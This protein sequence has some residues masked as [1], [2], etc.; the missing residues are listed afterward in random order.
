[1]DAFWRGEAI[2]VLLPSYWVE[3]VIPGG[4][5]EVC[6]WICRYES[7]CSRQELEFMRLLA[8]QVSI[9]CVQANLEEPMPSQSQVEVS[10]RATA[11]E[12]EN[13]YQ[14]LVANS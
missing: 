1:M 3:F 6:F 5:L 7:L 9:Q 11:F 8:S 2:E 10:A 12:R 14:Y 13:Y 4:G